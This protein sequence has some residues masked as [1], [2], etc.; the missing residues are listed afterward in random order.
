[1]KMY[2]LEVSSKDDLIFISQSQ[3]GAFDKVI[4]LH[5]E[6]ASILSEWIKNEYCA[7]QTEV[8]PVGFDAWRE[9]NHEV[10]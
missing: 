7:H 10:V 2:P 4:T 5:R 3:D 8:R 1:M 6:Q 9:R